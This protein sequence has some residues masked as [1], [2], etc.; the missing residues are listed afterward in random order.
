MKNKQAF[1]LIELLVV[2]LIIGILAAVAVPQYQKV[3]ERSKATQILTVIKTIYNAQLAYHMA[4]GTYANSFDELA[5]DI[6]LTDR[7]S[8]GSY[9]TDSR[10]ND[11]WGIGLIN[12]NGYHLIHAERLRGKYAQAGFE[13]Y[14]YHNNS[15]VPTDV[16]FCTEKRN[17]SPKFELERGEYCTK[18]MK[19]KY[20]HQGDPNNFF[21]MDGTTWGN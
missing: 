21:S 3:V 4:N 16:L 6:P 17:G 20:I 19:A 2:V 7:A 11:D 10:A 12:S 13:I 18:I 8:F 1:T 14:F 5:V 15:N 9:T